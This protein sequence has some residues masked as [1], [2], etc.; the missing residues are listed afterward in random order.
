[1]AT[2]SHDLARLSR[3]GVAGVAVVEVEAESV[4]VE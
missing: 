1:M 2:G 4:I 3:P